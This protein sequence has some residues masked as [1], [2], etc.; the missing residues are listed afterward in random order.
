MA[1]EIVD[2]PIE[3]GDFPVRYVRLPDGISWSGVYSYPGVSVRSCQAVKR[4]KSLGVLWEFICVCAYVLY[5][6][7]YIY[8]NICS[9]VCT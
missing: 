2:L 7:L 6:M 1:I 4:V 3:N 9:Y 5:S 8:S